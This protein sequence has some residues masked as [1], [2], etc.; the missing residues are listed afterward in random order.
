MPLFHHTGARIGR[1]SFNMVEALR[2]LNISWLVTNTSPVCEYLFGIFAITATE[3]VNW[4]TLRAYLLSHSLNLIKSVKGWLVHTLLLLEFARWQLRQGEK[5]LIH[6]W[7]LILSELP[8]ED[9]L[10]YHSHFSNVIG[11]LGDLWNNR[12]DL[13]NLGNDVGV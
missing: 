3:L 12:L 5:W 2:S 6:L 8:R 4:V 11:V 13:I 9:A 10:L 7:W 1:V